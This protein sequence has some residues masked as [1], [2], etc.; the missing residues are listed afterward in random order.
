M[1]DEFTKSVPV[2]ESVTQSGP[3]TA[4]SLPPSFGLT[5]PK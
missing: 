5:I 4:Y 2:G 1:K 3:L